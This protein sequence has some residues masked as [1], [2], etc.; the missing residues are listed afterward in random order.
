MTEDL[1]KKSD[2]YHPGRGHW[3]VGDS[4]CVWLSG[5][6]ADTS[7]L[8]PPAAA[9]PDQSEAHTA[10]S[11]QSWPNETVIAI[12]PLAVS[13]FPS[14]SRGQPSQDETFG[15]DFPP[16]KK[17]F[18]K[19]KKKKKFGRSRSVVGPLQVRPCGA[20]GPARCRVVAAPELSSQS[21]DQSAET[22]SAHLSERRDVIGPP[23]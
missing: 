9:A 23:S 11:A 21:C 2:H 10:F 8:P 7:S 22:A 13:A 5:P 3:G 16:T 14:I 15:A 17:I 18:V 20:C 6:A 19:K 12:Q 1:Q 4:L